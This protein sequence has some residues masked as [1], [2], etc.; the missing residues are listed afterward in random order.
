MTSQSTPDPPEPL[1]EPLRQLLATCPEYWPE[2]EATRTAFWFGQPPDELNP[3]FDLVFFIPH[4][5]DLARQHNTTCFPAVFALL[6]QLL[7]E[8]S[9]EVQ[10]WVVVGVLE[11]LQNQVSHTEL[12]YAAFEPWLGPETRKEWDGLIEAWGA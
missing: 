4:L 1:R 9:E 10:N 3:H 8:G 5:V 11:G 6:E 7:V 2:F 12:T